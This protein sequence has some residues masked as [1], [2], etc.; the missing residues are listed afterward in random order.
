VRGDVLGGM[1][2][3]EGDLPSGFVVFLTGVDFVG[4]VFA[5]VAFLSVAMGFETGVVVVSFLIA[6]GFVVVVDGFAELATGVLV[7]VT[8]V[9]LIGVDVPA[10]LGTGKVFCVPRGV[11]GLTGVAFAGVGAF[12]CAGVEADAPPALSFLG[13]FLTGNAA[14][15]AASVADVVGFFTGIALV[16]VDITALVGVAV[17]FFAVLPAP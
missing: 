9:F 13:A 1:G 5:D 4:I 2:M 14:V 8:G 16:V 10:G 17:D 6:V 12:G 3:E 7:V 11:L 15:S